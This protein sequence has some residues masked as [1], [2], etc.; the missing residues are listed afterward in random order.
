MSPLFTNLLLSWQLIIALALFLAILIL[1][2]LIY[3]SIL[4]RK[5][6]VKTSTFLQNQSL[7]PLPA[8]I[9]FDK[10][11]NP[12]L[13]LMRTYIDLSRKV[14][15]KYSVSIERGDTEKEVLD[16]ILK[17]GMDPN[18]KNLVRIY[19]LYEKIRFSQKNTSGDDLENAIFTAKELS[20]MVSR[21]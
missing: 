14:A 18:V 11:E 4:E 5:K 19:G 13:V 16:K 21:E 12:R 8:E 20:G 9:S 6:V 3:T 17:N 2:G 7:R 10:N 1:L 15:Q